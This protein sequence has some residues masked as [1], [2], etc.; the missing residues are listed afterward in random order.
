M[1]SFSHKSFEEQ[2][3]LL[4]SRGMLFSG[5]QDKKKA[6]QKLSIISYYKLKE[7]ARPFSKIVTVD[8]V[9]QINYQNTPFKKITVRYYQDKRLRLHL[10]DALEDIEVALKTQVAFV[11]GY[12][13]LGPYGYLNFS[14]W[15]NK[16]EYCKHY[17]KYREEK[18]KKQLK[19]E[20]KRTTSPEIKEKLKIDNMK[21][22]P[23]WLA[24]NLMTFGQIINLIELMSTNNIRQIAKQYDCSDAELLSWLK[25][26]NL[27]RNMCA[28]NS[29]I[30]DL[31]MHTTPILREEWKELLYELKE[32]VYSNRIALPIIIV[33]Y[34]MDAIDNQYNFR[35]I[36]GSFRKLIDKS[37]RQANYYGLKNKE[38]L[39]CLQHNSLYTR[40]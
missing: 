31:K 17:L 37:Q 11:L 6:E 22:P 30:I 40:I 3:A 1:S 15:C 35:E 39:N 23:I 27:L 7:F 20:L 9:R 8:G 29:S 2:V 25:C 19:A 10:L 21:Y 28:H 12:R 4:E 34:M 32:G 26:L 18:F 33:K 5:E 14:Q 36:F 24:I 38:V 13:R 16:K